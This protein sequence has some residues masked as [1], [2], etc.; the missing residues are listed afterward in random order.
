MSPCLKATTS[1]SRNTDELLMTN[2]ELMPKGSSKRGRPTKC[3]K[4]HSKWQSN[5]KGKGG[6]KEAPLV[7]AGFPSV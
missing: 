4:M 2:A 1:I 6:V 5:A 7:Y 3:F